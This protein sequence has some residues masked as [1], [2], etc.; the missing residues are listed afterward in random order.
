M[1]IRQEIEHALAVLENHRDI[2]DPEVVDTA[3]AALHDKLIALQSSSP[4]DSPKQMAVLV[5]DL[6]GFTAMS[7]LMD[8]EVVRD[9]INA[10]W[11]KLDSVIAAWG[12]HID[13]YIGDAVVAL[14]AIKSDLADCMERVVLSALDMQRELAYFNERQHK[15]GYTGRLSNLSAVL[16]LQMRIGIHFGPVMFGKMGS[17]QQFTAVGDTI[18]IAKQLERAASVGGILISETIYEQVHQLFDTKPVASILLDT[19]DSNYMAACT[20][21][22][23]KQHM[24]QSYEREI[25][26]FE[27][28]FVGRTTELELLQ[29]ALSEVTDSETAQVI[30]VVGDAGIGKTRLRQEFEK[31]LAIQP[32]PLHLFK[33][34]AEKRIAAGPYTALRHTLSNFFDIHPRSNTQV[35]RTKLV[36]GILSVLSADDSHARERAHFIG[37]LLGFDFV[38]SPYLQNFKHDARRVREYAFQ[39]LA[40]FF[41][42][43]S[44]DRPAV[45]LLDDMEQ[46]DEE[47][48]EFVEY[49]VDVCQ[50]RPLLIV[51]FGENQLN[52]KWSTLQL[53]QTIQPEKYRQIYLTPLS[54]IDN[55]HLIA[56]RLQ[57]IPRAPQRLTDLIAEAADGNPFL[58]TEI[59]E[60]LGEIG[61]IIRGSQ[62]WRVQMSPLSD[63]RGK[64]TLDWLVQKQL[65]RLSPL[66]KKIL[67]KASIVGET[68]WESTL[69]VFTFD[70]SGSVTERQIQ[71]A[72]HNL[73][74]LEV[75]VQRW[76]SAFA[77]TQE[78][79]FGHR[80]THQTIYNTMPLA[81]RQTAHVQCANWLLNQQATHLPHIFATIASH[82][83]KA[84][85]KVAASNW[86]GRAADQ[87]RHNFT[88]ALTRRLYQRALDLLP[89]TEQYKTRR[90]QLAEGLGQI[91]RQQ[92]QFDEA[93]TIYDQIY[94]QA[95]ADNDMDTAVRNF[96]SLFLIYNFQG[97]HQTALKI[98]QNANKIARSQNN[99]LGLINAQVAQGWTYL[100]LGEME[101]AV[102]CGKEAMAL[103][104][105][106]DAKRE[107][108]Y[109]QALL[110][111]IACH[112]RRF[113]QAQKATETAIQ[114]FREIGDRPWRVLMLYN[115]G[116]IAWLQQD[117]E[118][119]E[120][121]F[122]EGLEMARDVGD[123][124][125]AIRNLQGLTQVAQK[126][127]AFDQ[128][129]HFAQQVLIWAEK[130]G[131]IRFKILAAVE[132][133]QFYLAQ[134][135]LKETAVEQ[136]EQLRRARYWLEHSQPL[137][138]QDQQHLPATIW[139]ITMAQL[140]RAEKRPAKALAQIQSAL[141]LIREQNVASHGVVA[142][143]TSAAAWRELANI[144]AQ[145]PPA[146]LPI[147]INNEPHQVADCYQKSLKI[148]GEVK[149]GAKLEAAHTLFAW[150]IYEIRANHPRRGETLWQQAYAIYEQLGM[151]DEIAKMERF[152]I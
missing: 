107:A 149:N 40:L 96:S 50:E 4:A 1:T 127:R 138:E 33:G 84:G 133:S 57:S 71:A 87:A 38:Q 48:F 103:S 60:M 150:A 77:Q 113:E 70:E 82:L 137:V 145:M 18:T 49:L 101:Q 44:E 111:D 130:S 46:A 120:S 94:Q 10:I 128:A 34:Q 97:E 23:E 32:T 29:F 27:T 95:I 2:L 51:C 117:V 63:L 91:L 31:F 24:L 7:E 9:T 64:L 36:D 93:I 74:R 52:A 76:P 21:Q 39:D 102:Q 88:P 131:N 109:C 25:S 14:F 67:Q 148:L 132:L 122:T 141:K 81:D 90:G 116:Q 11:Q 146:S 13:Q 124:L 47:T 45:I 98:A 75:I 108:A 121:R 55:R 92:A 12:G 78:F 86:Y 6:S 58:I 56:D 114:L 17:S 68:F 59:I 37:Y 105:K 20:V 115:L 112:L 85:D 136:A 126:R 15:D 54:L 72:V 83:E 106:I 28:R 43:I 118:Q 80:R 139:Q 65:D 3:M 152:A 89:Q 151:M 79:Q 110:G 142:R 140:L 35:A 62:Q 69:H 123:A 125:G 100:Y 26:P 144:A 135:E 73:E 30:T 61:V 42:A 134:E 143:K 41:S 16:D 147:F 104:N 119:A 53:Y 5:A 19:E 8:A 129:E 22:K 99:T 66:E